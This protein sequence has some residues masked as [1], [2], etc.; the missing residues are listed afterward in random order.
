MQ[1]QLEELVTPFEAAPRKKRASKGRG[2]V[3]S[4]ELRELKERYL[5]WMLA[6]RYAEST[7]AGAN[8]DVEWLYRFLTLRGIER[9]ADV[10]PELLNEYSL[11]FRE[12]KPRQNEAKAVSIHHLV[13]RLNGARWFFKWLAQNMIVLADPAEDLEI[14]RIV[15][16]L[17][18]TILTQEE[19]RRLM[20]APNL[21][22][23]VGYRDRALLEVAYGTGIRSGELFK[24]QV[25]DFDPKARTVFVR[26]GKGGKDRIIPLP[27]TAAG[28]LAE[29][30]AKVRPKFAAGMKG[31]DDGTLFVNY[32]G[33]KLDSSRMADLFRRS[34]ASAGIDKH[35]TCMV[36]R[37]SIATHLLENGMSIR[38]IQEFLGHE[39]MRTTTLYSKATLKGLRRHYN[40]HHPRE[41][42]SR[43]TG[44]W[45]M[46]GTTR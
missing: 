8:E 32:T 14:P 45:R 7:I 3:A 13:H 36:L 23:P 21:K 39:D 20:D 27:A 25:S 35:V 18:Q 22:S 29:Y 12:H 6:T 5:S 4:A 10:T 26:Q 33:G 30:V 2:F 46:I 41:K 38:Y 42:R 28:Y 37:H 1:P 16:S 44:S 31:G 15:R 9:I 24:L 43:Q 11:W 40:K 34:T 19:A 17:P